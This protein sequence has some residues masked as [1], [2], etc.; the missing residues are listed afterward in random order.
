MTALAASR[1]AASTAA[2]TSGRGTGATRPRDRAAIYSSSS[3]MYSMYSMYSSSRRARAAVSAN[4]GRLSKR[5]PSDS[6]SETWDGEKYDMAEM[7]MWD[8]PSIEGPSC[9]R[10]PPIEA[11][12]VEE[13]EAL[14]AQA[15]N[16]Y[17]SGQPV[18]DDAM[19]DTVERR[20][21]YLGSDAA[22]KYPRCSRR[23]MRV[24][25]DAS[26]DSQQL[27]SLASTW[28]F[29]VALGCAMVAWD[30]GD[31]MRA[32]VGAVAGGDIGGPHS[33]SFRPPV[34]GLLGVFLANGGWERFGRLR[35]G[36]TVAVKGECPSCAEEVYAFLP[37]NRANARVE[38]E[39]HVCERR[40]AFRVEVAKS[41]N[42]KWRRVATGRIYL[43][44]GGD[45]GGGEY[46]DGVGGPPRWPPERKG[47]EEGVGRE[48]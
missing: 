29:L 26:F 18:V 35:D 4:A 7:G 16:T 17:F 32:G 39:C 2:S 8:V 20:L 46:R 15:K 14:Y 13:L 34:I 41:E 43:V 22:V 30:F 40:L 44:G 11:A 31:A 9:I 1:A 21:R 6:Y 48:R 33:S 3:S 25:S 12:T 37:G 47:K 42:A 27:D 28:L 5:G 24:Y 45:G 19:F 36:N 10:L 23:D 38:C